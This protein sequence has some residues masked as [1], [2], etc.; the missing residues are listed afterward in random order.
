VEPGEAFLVEAVLNLQMCL[1]KETEVRHSMQAPTGRSSQKR[2]QDTAF[3]GLLGTFRC[4]HRRQPDYR[5]KCPA[6]YRHKLPQ[7]NPPVLPLGCLLAYFYNL[8]TY[9]RALL[10]M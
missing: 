9:L 5:R 6:L 10:D 1:L 3:V 2:T 4:L 7:R 8:N